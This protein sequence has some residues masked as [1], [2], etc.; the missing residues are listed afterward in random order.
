MARE[1]LRTCTS[2]LWLAA[3]VYYLKF[4]LRLAEGPILYSAY[5]VLGSACL[6]MFPYLWVAYRCLIGVGGHRVGPLAMLLGG[7]SR[8]RKDWV[9]QV[10]EPNE[11]LA[12]LVHVTSGE[13][14]RIDT[15]MK[16]QRL[17]GEELAIATAERMKLLFQLDEAI[18]SQWR[19]EAMFVG[20]PH[21]DR[22]QAFASDQIERDVRLC[23]AS[24]VL[25]VFTV[26]DHVLAY[27]TGST[28]L[29]LLL[30]RR[31][32]GHETKVRAAIS[33]DKLGGSYQ[34][35]FEIFS[36][37]F[38]LPGFV[39]SQAGL[40]P[41]EGDLENVKQ[42]LLGSPWSAPFRVGIFS[43]LNP[44]NLFRVLNLVFQGLGCREEAAARHSSLPYFRNNYLGSGDFTDLCLI[45]KMRSTAMAQGEHYHGNKIAV[46]TERMEQAT[47]Q[48]TLT[49]QQEIQKAIRDTLE[50]AAHLNAV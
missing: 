42:D 39:N 19:H 36:A 12:E 1:V 18:P 13:L 35:C 11:R 40:I 50:M 33:L 22:T 32:T 6:L 30:D 26:F 45:N 38:F 31:F 21:D 24:V 10:A 17:R 2:V 41:A 8:W 9:E 46:P 25:Q 43:L 23:L 29:V 48:L 44:L 7:H 15:N 27:R 28:S 14:Q 5:L 49:L 3:L 4:S 47:E 16:Q 37:Y 20:K 34:W